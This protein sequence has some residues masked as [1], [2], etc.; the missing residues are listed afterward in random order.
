MSEEIIN[1]INNARRL[2]EE[3]HDDI[4]D[5]YTMWEVEPLVEENRLIEDILNNYCKL[6]VALGVVKFIGKS[7]KRFI[8][9]E[10]DITNE[11]N[12]K[13]AIKYISNNIVDRDFKNWWMNTHKHCK[14]Q[15]FEECIM[16]NNN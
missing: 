6:A 8:L 14:G 11:K 12:Y 7:K 9:I 4:G 15:T 10:D 5:D 1:K 3:L 13:K 16:V 2:I